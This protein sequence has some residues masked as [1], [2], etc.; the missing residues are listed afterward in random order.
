M[1][2]KIILSQISSKQMSADA[3]K[4]APDWKPFRSSNRCRRPMRAELQ[5]LRP[6]QSRR[7]VIR[8]NHPEE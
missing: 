8:K 2:A 5:S 7:L 6:E 3:I 1:T 4:A